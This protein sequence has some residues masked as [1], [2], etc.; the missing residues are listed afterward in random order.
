MLGAFRPSAGKQQNS[1]PAF[2]LPV[3]K[4]ISVGS[5]CS[6]YWVIDFLHIVYQERMWVCSQGLGFLVPGEQL[7]ECSESLH[8]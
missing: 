5:R 6:A 2:H 1:A 8:L 4:Q 7:L 3:E